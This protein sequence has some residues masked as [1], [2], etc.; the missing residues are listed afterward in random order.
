MAARPSPQR[1]QARSGADIPIDVLLGAVR[2]MTVTQRRDGQR[3]PGQRHKTS[4]GVNKSRAT[5]DQT[6]G[7]ARSDREGRRGIAWP[8]RVATWPEKTATWPDRVATWAK[9]SGCLRL[10]RPFPQSEVRPSRVAARFRCPAKHSARQAASRTIPPGDTHRRPR[11]RGVRR[12]LVVTPKVG[13]FDPLFVDN[14]VECGDRRGH[15][16]VRHGGF[17]A[18]RQGVGPPARPGRPPV[19]MQLQPVDSRL[20]TAGLPHPTTTLS[21]DR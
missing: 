11:P 18:Q 17:H 13:W 19:E 4:S 9:E 21:G 8:E 15:V 16:W 6:R 7:I 2:S 20:K 5:P 14:A 3:R 1:A 12:P 10:S